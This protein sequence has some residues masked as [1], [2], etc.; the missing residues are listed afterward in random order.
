MRRTLGLLAISLAGCEAA[1]PV[2]DLPWL[3][4]MTNVVSTD[5]GREGVVGR[6]AAWV[7]PDVECPASAYDGLEL[8]ADVASS[9]GNETILASYTQGVIVLSAEGQLLA[10]S[11]GYPCEG[12]ADGVEALAAGT[13]YGVPTIALLGTHGGKREN[14]AW[15]GLFRMHGTALDPV[16]AGTVE[17]REGTRVRR[18]DILL[19][20]GGT[21]IYRRP[22]GPPTVWFY[23]AVGRAYVPFGPIDRKEPPHVPRTSLL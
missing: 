1:A 22:G 12:S 16:F 9:P 10:S 15:I 6:M 19:A 5:T 11:A 17:E 13:S 7:E 8:V 23:D 18:G 20:P 14:A 4:G 21:L 3:S 2:P